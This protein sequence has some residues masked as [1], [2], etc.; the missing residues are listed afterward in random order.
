MMIPQPLIT[1]HIAL[2]FSMLPSIQ[3]N[4]QATLATSEIDDVGTNRAL[5]D[6]FEPTQCART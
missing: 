1:N 5:S 6:E 2:T 3:F 4:D